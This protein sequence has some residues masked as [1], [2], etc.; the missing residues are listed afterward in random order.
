MPAR[1]ET[2]STLEPIRSRRKPKTASTPARENIALPIQLN[3]A[4]WESSRMG[5]QQAIETL[6]HQVPKSSLSLVLD[7]LARCAPR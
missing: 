5:K 3:A 6:E 1:A 7:E 2:R 4:G